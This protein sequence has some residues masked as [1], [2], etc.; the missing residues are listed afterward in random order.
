MIDPASKPDKPHPAAE[1]RDLGLDFCAVL[2]LDPAGRITAANVSARLLWQTGGSELLGEAFVSLFEFDVVSRDADFLNAQWDAVLGS[3]LDRQTVLTA[4]P[5]EA[6]P[7]EVHV[8]IEML[9]GAP[10]AGYVATVQPPPRL[11]PAAAAHTTAGLSLLAE[12]GAVGFFDLDC[13]A[14]RAQLSPAWKKILGYTAAEL[15]DTIAAWRQLVLP[16]D[17]AA[18]PD[19]VGKKARLGVRTFNTELRMRHQLGHWVW[20]QCLGVQSFSDAG[21]LERVAG[22]QLD[23]TERKEIEDT[24]TANDARLEDLSGSGPLAAFELDFANRV[25]WFSPAW[26]RLLGYAEG[27]LAP[28]VAS[29]A[30]ALPADEASHGVVAWLLSRAPGESS[31]LEV[32]RLR[33]KNGESLPAVFGAHRTVNR[34]RELARVVGFACP[35]PGGAAEPGALPPALAAEVMST[36][37]EGVIVTDAAGAV[38]LANATAARLL[39]ADAT[40]L[41]GRPLA[42][43][44]RLINR[45]SGLPGDNP[46]ERALATDRPLPL[47]DEHSLLSAASSTSGGTAAAQPVVWTSRVVPGTDGKPQGVVIIFRNPEE[48]TLTPEELVKANRFESLGLLAGGIAHDFNNL[49]TTILGAVSL[50]KDNRDYSALADAEKAIDAARGL[51]RQLLAFAKGSGGTQVV[52]DARPILED[53]LKIAAAA[54]AAAIEL[55]AGPDTDPV[56][57]DRAQI[58]QVFQNLIINALQAMPPL[59]HRPRLQ[60]HARNIVLADQQVPSLAAGDYVEFEVRDNGSGIKPEHIEK[61][62]A[63]FFT[64]KKHGTGLGLATVLSIVR[65]HGGQIALDT[66]VGVGTAFTVYLPKATQPVGTAARPAP[67][68]RFGTGSIL[69]MDDDPKIAALTATMLQSLGYK[70]R[71]AH[72]GV[73]AIKL[74]RDSLNVARPYD[75]VI[76]DL[77]IIGGMG[78]EECF[79]ELRKLDPDVRAIVASGYDHDDTER[80]FMAMGFCGFLRKPY[81]VGDVGKMLKTVIG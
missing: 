65:K 22:V 8:R 67:T 32:V 34:K 17:T 35:L 52:C 61:I 3:A 14:G 20:V 11:A 10:A 47:I 78:G 26:K 37:A 68:M 43:V 4:Q 18:A 21:E 56:R 6:P 30:A 62:F 31:F 1:S 28:E 23:I 24:L 19:H 53:S 25:F 80:K 44:F 49:L 38:R 70:C 71:I 55:E 81:R 39:R 5:R 48:M 7:R 9:M 2:L 59:P 13:A 29:L 79:H 74:Y 12:K 41:R 60:I 16:D 64:T 51:T 75:A 46:I 63:P 42:E 40:A 36:L 76:M 45:Q 72:D 54:S 66:Q 69:F 57:V 73:E 77:T 33:A 15:A 50:A 27:E 58:L